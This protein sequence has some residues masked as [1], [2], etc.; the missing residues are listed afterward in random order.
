LFLI[1]AHAWIAEVEHEH[2]G[3][4]QGGADQ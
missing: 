2:D 3:T 4:W 1:A